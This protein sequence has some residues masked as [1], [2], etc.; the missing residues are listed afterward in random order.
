MDVGKYSRPMEHL[1][2]DTVLPWGLDTGTRCK[3][4]ES[5]GTFF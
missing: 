2:T 3:V 4:E 1:G 5:K